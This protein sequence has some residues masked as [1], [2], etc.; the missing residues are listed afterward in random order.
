MLPEAISL[1]MLEDTSILWLNILL[2][3]ARKTGNQR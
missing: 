3:Q 1:M 2:L